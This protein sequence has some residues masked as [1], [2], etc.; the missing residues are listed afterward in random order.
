MLDQVVMGPRYKQLTPRER[1]LIGIWLAEGH[2]KADIGRRLGRSTSTISREIAR[3]G[4]RIRKTSY[5]PHAAQNR[6][7]RRR[8]QSYVKRA[9]MHDE[10]LRTYV[11]NRLKKKWS[12]ELIAGRL[13]LDRP[14]LHISHEAIYQWIYAEGKEY[15]AYLARKHRKRRKKGVAR[16]GHKYNIPSRVSIDERP[17]E[18]NRRKEAGHWEVDTAFFHHCHEVLHV[19]AERKTRYTMLT[20]LKDIAMRESRSAMLQRHKYTPKYLRKSFTYDNGR[21]NV[22]HVFVNTGL[23]STSYFCHPGRSWEKGTVENTIGVIRR[24]LPK[25]TKFSAVSV[26]RVKII[27]DWLND[28]PRKCLGFRT[29]REAYSAERCTS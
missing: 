11:T 10:Q 1:D 14:H 29:P 12:P 15:V 13:A 5:L 28:R 25:K 24:L 2:S 26:Q 19:M 6:S 22:G 27:E 23:G 4:P 16:K 20:K 7:T 9:K 18:I 21:E 3:N 17:E 8:R